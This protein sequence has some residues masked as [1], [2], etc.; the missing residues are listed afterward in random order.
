MQVRARLKYP[1]IV[2]LAGYNMSCK[3]NVYHIGSF[4]PPL[5]LNLTTPYLLVQGVWVNTHP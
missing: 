1:A 5:F 4:P 3:A 2:K